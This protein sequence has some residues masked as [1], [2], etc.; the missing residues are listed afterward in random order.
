M[1]RSDMTR[2]IIQLLQDYGV[3]MS[4]VRIGTSIMNLIETEGMQP[5]KEGWESEE[6]SPDQIDAVFDAVHPS[7]RRWCRAEM[8]ACMGC[9]NG[10]YLVRKTELTYADWLGYKARKGLP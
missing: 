6:L 1:K 4:K 8:C 10:D 7:A 9:V 5:P 2:K 3:A